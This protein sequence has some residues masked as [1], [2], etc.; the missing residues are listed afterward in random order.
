MTANPTILAKA[1]EGSDV[2]DEQF[3]SLI[4]GGATISDA[5]WE[6]VVED[7]RGALSVLRPTFESSEGTDGFVSIE[8]A[9]ELAHD[10]EA[11]V[12]AARELHRR[13]D[14]PNL[15]GQNPCHPRRGS[16]PY[17]R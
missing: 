9:P 7:V 5:Y 12:V 6:L 8:V 11:T 4:D 2:Y 16:R 15:Y 13:I 17:R 14:Q 1:I 10:T 3:A